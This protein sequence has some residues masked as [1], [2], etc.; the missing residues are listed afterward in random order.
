V[1]SGSS[2]SIKLTGLSEAAQIPDWLERGQRAM[3]EEIAEELA[4]AIGDASGS[5][6][7]RASFRGRAISSTKAI[8]E[9]RGTKFAKARDRGAYITPR[10]GKVIRFAD[11]SFR[12]VARLTPHKYVAK[13]MRK[14]RAIG[15]AAFARHF[16]DLK[17]NA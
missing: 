11:G 9:S 8:V 14:R 16:G 1:A 6:Q 4:E 13:G 10:N 2:F 15:D 12:R 17:G 3:L 5:S 7:I